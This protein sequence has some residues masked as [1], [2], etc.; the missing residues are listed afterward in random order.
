MTPRD[1]KEKIGSGLLSFPV[2]PFDSGNRF[3]P[4]P[5]AAHIEWL[6]Q[7]PAAGLFAAGG[8]GEFFSLRPEEVVDAVRTAKAAAGEV[9]ILSGCG[10]GTAM[11]V[12]LAK[13]VEAAGADGLLLLPHYLTE[14]GQTGLAAHVKA[15]CDAVDIGVV[16][17]N[18]ANFRLTAATLA[19]LCEQ[20]PNLI[21][22]KDG[23]GDI[24]TVRRIVATF[25]DRLTYIGGMPTHEFYA[26]AYNAMGVTTYSS[27]VFNF[28]PDL[29]LEFFNAMRSD[30]KA[31]MARLLD[32]F[33]YPFMDIRDRQPGYA[34]SAIKAGVR[35]QGL[36]RRPGAQPA[37][38]PDRRGG[39]DARRA[40][41][42]IR[43][44]RADGAGDGLA[45]VL[46]MGFA[47][48]RD[49]SERAAQVAPHRCLGRLGLAGEQRVE[50]VAV[51]A[52]DP[53]RLALRRQVQVAQPIDVAA[54]LDDELPQP[55]APDGLEQRQVERLVL[56]SEGRG[57]A[58]LDPDR[59]HLVEHELR[60]PQIELARARGDG[61]GDF[62]LERR[63][64]ELRLM[65]LFEVDRRHEGAGLG[66]DD[67]EFLL[68]QPKQRVPDRGLAD[69]KAFRQGRP[70]QRRARS[71]LQGDDLRS[72]NLEDL[73]RHRQSA[74][75]ADVVPIRKRTFE[76]V[77]Q[78]LM[79]DQRQV[80]RR[81]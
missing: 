9:P 33:F 16:V 20:C 57:I 2:T 36:R 44:P 40:R 68:F 27:A 34:V 54:A 35:L 67:H 12:D 29:A 75:E 62:A 79:A 65:C 72:Q 51:V 73:R 31:T 39:A 63:A 19:R 78:L 76:H 50:D 7:Y 77:R 46:G 1:L 71:Q 26:E 60:R 5:Y 47:N 70:R 64:Q 13:A 23:T 49:G 66:V 52:Q 15:V 45:E 32:D 8:T 61:A 3:A 81:H 24:A 25:G 48:L 42:Q 58:V 37:D 69:A 55:L 11:A 38:R 43:R 59:F 80:S 14:A 21:G 22:F 53:R 10:Y 56:R 74:V 18:R 41:R 30:D 6:A 28:V 17:Y 4:K